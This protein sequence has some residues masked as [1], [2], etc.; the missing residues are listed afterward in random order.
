M[1]IY[2]YNP[3][4]KYTPQNW[5]GG[6]INLSKNRIYVNNNQYIDLQFPDIFEKYKI[7]L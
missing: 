5:S 6:G 1:S 7:I 3:K 4:V 2:T